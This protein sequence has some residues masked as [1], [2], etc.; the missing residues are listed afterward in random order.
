MNIWKIFLCLLLAAPLALVGGCSDDDDAN[1]TAP[2]PIDQFEIVREALHAYVA[3]TDGPV[4][5]AQGVFD[6]IY[7]GDDTNDYYVLSVRSPQHYAIGH[8]PGAA[9]SYWKDAC[10]PSSIAALP[11]DQP[12]AVVCYT[13]HTGAVATTAL[14]A[15]GYDAYNLKYGMMAWTTEPTVRVQAAFSEAVDAH[16]FALETTV[17]TPGTYDLPELDVTESSNEQDIILAAANFYLQ[18]TDGPVITAQ[19]LFDN[20][21]DGD[22]TN[23]YYV[24]SVRSAE[25]YALGHI[26][27]AINIPWRTIT[28]VDN[29]RKIP[30]DQP[31]AVVCYTGHT[32]GVATTALRM[33]GYEAYNV[34]HGMMAWT[35]DATV[36]VQSAFREDVDAHDFPTE[37]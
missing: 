21:N 20:I 18:G 12:I 31:I 13:A 16:D 6:N 37:P 22:D 24:I 10:L 26:P 27:G 7:D 33:L 35:T 11:T 2:N 36:R 30:A 29:L 34:K 3:G 17:N 28:S 1:P 8:I 19:A 4:V 14:Q 25:H 23:D 9:N 5:T 15:L 32:A